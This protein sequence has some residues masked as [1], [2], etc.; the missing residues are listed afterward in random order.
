MVV[1]VAVA[2]G[3]DGDGDGGV[4]VAGLVAPRGGAGVGGE[5]EGGE[6]KEGL[7]VGEHA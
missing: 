5:E 2:G 7:H 6:D 1:R 3:G 4:T